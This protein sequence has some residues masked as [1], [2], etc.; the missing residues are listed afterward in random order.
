MYLSVAESL[1]YMYIFFY[2]HT[3]ICISDINKVKQ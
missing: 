1:I 2:T 3:Y